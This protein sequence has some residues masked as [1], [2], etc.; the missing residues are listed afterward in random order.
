VVLAAGDMIEPEDVAEAV[1]QGI[2]AEQFLILPHPVV[3]EYV[4]RK[5]ED[6]DRWIRG[7]RKLQARVTGG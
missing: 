6:P 2:R 4:R 7:M 5:G 3:A 1:V